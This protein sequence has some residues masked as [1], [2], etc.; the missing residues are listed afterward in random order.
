MP[1]RC[2]VSRV[3]G[4]LRNEAG[5]ESYVA[6]F[7]PVCLSRIHRFQEHIRKLPAENIHSSCRVRINRVHH[8]TRG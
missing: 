5:R 8:S 1:F 4:G 2:S 6:R 3:G 7:P